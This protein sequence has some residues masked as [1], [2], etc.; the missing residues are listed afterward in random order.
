MTSRLSTPSCAPTSYARINPSR[1]CNF[2]YLVSLLWKLDSPLTVSVDIRASSNRNG[3]VSADPVLS[4]LATKDWGKTMAGESVEWLLSCSPLYP[5]FL[6]NL[7]RSVTNVGSMSGLSR[8]GENEDVYSWKRRRR[9]ASNETRKFQCWTRTIRS[10]EHGQAWGIKKWGSPSR[11]EHPVSQEE[12]QTASYRQFHYHFTNLFSRFQ[13]KKPSRPSL[14]LS[15][16]P[17]HS[18]RKSSKR[19]K[20]SSPSW[21]LQPSPPSSPPWP[22][23]HQLR[24]PIWAPPSFL[25]W[26]SSST[27]T[28]T[29]N[30]K[31]MCPWTTRPSPPAAT[32]PPSSPIRPSSRAHPRG[33]PW[34]WF[35]ARATR[36]RP[37]RSK[38][39]TP[40]AGT[41]SPCSES[42]VRSSQLGHWDVASSSTRD[43]MRR[44]GGN[45][46]C[47]EED[48]ERGREEREKIEFWKWLRWSWICDLICFLISLCISFELFIQSFVLRFALLCCFLF[49]FILSL[50]FI[51]YIHIR[52]YTQILYC[53]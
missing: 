49:P 6:R 53:T 29:R 15:I 21:P 33:S 24:P 13:S 41:I 16:E 2:V 47:G 4:M 11:I 38:S 22:P 8:R 35:S 43:P 12:H 40:S 44:R 30:P 18:S 7:T 32:S 10:R 5:V 26:R 3:P 52:T 34:P 36:T 20:C 25:P 19:T 37:A 28:S 9:E 42:E 23:R 39:A 46:D 45:G 14:T 17:V 48:S 50:L 31:L 27:G 1:T 51:S